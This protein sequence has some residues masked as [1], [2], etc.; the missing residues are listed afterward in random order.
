MCIYRVTSWLICPFLKCPTLRHSL[1]SLIACMIDCVFCLCFADNLAD[2]CSQENWS[3]Y[4][5]RHRIRLEKSVKIRRPSIVDFQYNDTHRQRLGGGGR[6][7]PSYSL[8]SDSLSQ[9]GPNFVPYCLLSFYAD[10]GYRIY[11]EGFATGEY[12]HIT[13][14]HLNPCSANWWQ[15]CKLRATHDHSFSLIDSFNWTLHWMTLTD[16]QSRDSFFHWNNWT[17]CLIVLLFCLLLWSV[18]E[19][20]NACETVVSSTV[21]AAMEVLVL[22]VGEKQGRAIGICH[23]YKMISLILPIMLNAIWCMC[24]CMFEIFRDI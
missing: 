5:G 9:R 14:F 21:D 16:V 24:V 19:F 3:D 13:H 17:P 22:V 10:Y 7:G 6:Y 1:L 12:M 18:S 2:Y 4:P 20:P 8:L 15:I 23:L 11:A